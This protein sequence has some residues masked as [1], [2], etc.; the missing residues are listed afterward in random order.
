MKKFVLTLTATLLALGATTV[1]GCDETVSDLTADAQNDIHQY[2]QERTD[3]R[4]G[5]VGFKKTDGQKQVVRGR[6]IYILEYEAQAQFLERC[7]TT[8]ALGRVFLCEDE[9][10]DS[11]EILRAIAM[12]ND[13]MKYSTS[14]KGKEVSIGGS[15]TFE[16]KESGWHVIRHTLKVEADEIGWGEVSF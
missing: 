7:W 4:V 5:V 13:L 9:Y 14:D 8:R 3:G 16:K 2:I 11:N 15:V 6:D 12:G 10:P 1:A